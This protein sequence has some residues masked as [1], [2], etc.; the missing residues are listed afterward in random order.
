MM[1]EDTFVPTIADQTK[2]RGGQAGKRKACPSTHRRPGGQE[3]GSLQRRQ[4]ARL[5]EATQGTR[6][7]MTARQVKPPDRNRFQ[8]QGSATPEKVIVGQP[9]KGAEG[10]Q[11]K[12]DVACW[13]SHVVHRPPASHVVHRRSGSVYDAHLCPSGEPGG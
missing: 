11:G 10:K 8:K 2:R 1:R 4:D 5:R 12:E 7:A 6:P 9:S 13:E 3:I